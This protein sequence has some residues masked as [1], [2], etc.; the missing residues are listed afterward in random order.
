MPSYPLRPTF[1]V[2]VRSPSGTVRIG[3]QGTAVTV[4]VTGE[5]LLATLPPTTGQFFGALEGMF[6][7]STATLAG[8]V[9]ADPSSPVHRAYQT[10]AF[11]SAECALLV[12]VKATLGLTDL[13]VESLL[14]AAALQ[15]K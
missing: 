5:Q 6:P 7:G 2:D 3:R 8:A 9:P 12:F 15:P 4:D 11:I 13:Q 10:T 1:P 14:A